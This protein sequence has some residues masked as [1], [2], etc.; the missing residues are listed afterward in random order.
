MGNTA[1][2]TLRGKFAALSVHIRRQKGLESMNYVNK[3]SLE[4]KLLQ[5]KARI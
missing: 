2:K 3:T 4:S 5:E 1:K